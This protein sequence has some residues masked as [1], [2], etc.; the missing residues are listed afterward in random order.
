MLDMIYLAKKSQGNTFF[1]NTY[2]RFV[3]SESAALSAQSFKTKSA[4]KDAIGYANSLIGVLFSELVKDSGLLKM[5]EDESSA[6]GEA[7]SELYYSAPAVH[8][9]KA[10]ERRVSALAACSEVGQFIDER[11]AALRDIAARGLVL[12]AVP[13]I[14]KI[15]RKAT[16]MQRKEAQWKALPVAS[17]AL[18]L[19]ITEE[20][21]P[22]L[23]GIYSELRT[24]LEKIRI[25]CE[26]AKGM[27]RKERLTKRRGLVDAYGDLFNVAWAGERHIDAFIQGGFA[28]DIAAIKYHAATRLG[29]IEVLDV[30]SSDAVLGKAGCEYRCR[31]LTND[32]PYRFH[33]RGIF[34]GGVNIQRCHI[35]VICDLKREG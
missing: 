18:V 5:D 31:L 4:Q 15:S 28:D 14:K 22:S 21:T 7:A 29:G 11:A 20:I 33:V 8:T 24:L 3:A 17:K 30:L 6:V 34:A 1:V 13:V 35:R 16:E 27:T 12:K 25:E 19:R 9:M 10:F 26:R 32:G 2:E 23:E